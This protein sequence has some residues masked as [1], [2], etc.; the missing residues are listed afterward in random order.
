MKT[1][2]YDRK[3]IQKMSETSLI[4]YCEFNSEKVRDAVKSFLTKDKGPDFEDET[5]EVLRPLF[6]ALEDLQ[7]P[8]T[9]LKA[10]NIGMFIRFDILIVSDN[11]YEE[12]EAKEIMAKLTTGG[13][14]KVYAYFYDDEEYEVYWSIERGKVTTI[15]TPEENEA[16]DEILVNLDDE[17]RLAKVAELY[18]AGRL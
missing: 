17:D 14:A 13:A 8:D 2:T 16:I 4:I 3:L 10:G 1:Q 6:L 5:E 7:Y 15:F 11:Y 12:D 18:E 9:I